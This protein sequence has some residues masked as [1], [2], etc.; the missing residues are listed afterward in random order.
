VYDPSTGAIF[1]F[2]DPNAIGEKN[3]T[4]SIHIWRSDDLGDTWA[5]V[6]E[7]A[8]LGARAEGSGLANGV[9]L[10]SGRIVVA[11]RNGCNAH[12]ADGAHAL[13]S[14]DHGATWVAGQAVPPAPPAIPG[15]NECQIAPLR[16]GSLLLMA[17]AQSTTLDADGPIDAN[18]VSAVSDDG[19]ATWSAPRVERSL[20]GF[21]TCE[22]SIISHGKGSVLLFSHPEGAGGSRTNLIIRASRDDGDS[23]P[24][25]AADV[26]VVH[27]GASAYSCLGATALGEAAV[28]WEAD[29][30]DLVFATTKFFGAA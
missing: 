29:G 16:N 9:V 24:R 12:K 10:P 7:T 26:L 20:A 1:L 6:E 21:A 25:G 28:L 27:A 14:D 5:L 18:R 4:C 17:R 3:A 2:D 11:H 30:K 8:R 13:W 22:G 23:W 19:G 15:A